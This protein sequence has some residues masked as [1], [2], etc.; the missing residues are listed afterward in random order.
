MRRQIHFQIL[1]AVVLLFGVSARL[2]ASSVEG[3]TMTVG[4]TKTLYL[5]LSVTSHNPF[6]CAFSLNKTGYLKIISST[7]NS[8]KVEALKPTASLSSV[9]VHCIYYYYVSSGGRTSVMQGNY[10]F[11]VTI[12]GKAPTSISL[13]KEKTVYV[14]VGEYL[15]PTI[16][17][18]DA[19]TELTWSS[20][21]Y[22][23]INV[24]QDGRILAQRT[25]TSVIT[26]KTQNGLSA[27][28]TVTAIKKTVNP[29]SISLSQTSVTLAIGQSTTLS[30]IVSP[31]DATDKSVTW[32][33]LYDNV[34]SVYGGKVTALKEGKT[35]ITATTVNGL[36]TTCTVMVVLPTLKITGT[37]E[38]L[39]VPAL[40]NLDYSRFFSKGW[41]SLCVPFGLTV[42]ELETATGLTG[43]RIATLKE[44]KNTGF[45]FEYVES[46]SGGTP[47]IV[48][49]PQD[50]T[51]SIKKDRV[52]LATAPK[53]SSPMMGTYTTK[54]IGPGY[55]KLNAE[56]T[57]FGLT[58]ASD[59][60]I[61][62]SRIYI[63]QQ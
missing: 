24:D 51:V 12:N 22:S 59:A 28:C 34:A 15:K 2:G 55:Y 41:N 54:T 35:I 1:I 44:V 30:A 56:G 46:V 11:C 39:N 3:V 10:D 16:S 42:H 48:Y 43:C 52:T 19:Y 32:S 38:I 9:N 49:F 45:L 47:C 18:T 37:S 50:A 31:S 53:Q 8:V 40:A 5:P 33:S 29:T 62:A 17:P 57:A 14:G 23:T 36:S 26:V 21:A 4:E 61:K 27:S 13:P 7:N 6:N 25:G 58:T 63:K 60:Y 20:S